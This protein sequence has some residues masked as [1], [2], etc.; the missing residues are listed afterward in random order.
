MV[1]NSNVITLSED[2]LVQIDKFIDETLSRSEFVERILR[3]YLIERQAK[4]RE[5][6]DLEII[7]THADY[8]NREAEDVLEYQIEI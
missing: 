6:Q 3:K 8:L 7:N 5:L 4:K 2:I 1:K